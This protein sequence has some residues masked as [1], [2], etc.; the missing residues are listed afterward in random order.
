MLIS[1]ALQH[2]TLLG[3]GWIYRA[4]VET[5]YKTFPYYSPP[6]LHFSVLIVGLNFI[7][8]VDISDPSNLQ[9]PYFVQVGP[10]GSGEGTDVETCGTLV[11][12][13]YDSFVDPLDGRVFI[14]ST[15]D[16]NADEPMKLLH[17]IPG[18]PRKCNKSY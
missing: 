7:H 9:R 17:S 1:L 14:Y 13:S 5:F 15:Y 11:A 12:A 10:D 18:K 3:W 8:V 6:Q 16:A 2:V 4:N